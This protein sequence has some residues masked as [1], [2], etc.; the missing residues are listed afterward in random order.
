MANRFDNIPGL[1][2][3]YQQ[4]SMVVDKPFIGTDVPDTPLKAPLDFYQKKLEER[5]KKVEKLDEQVA[6]IAPLFNV[7]GQDKVTGYNGITYDINEDKEAN[8]ALAPYLKDISEI[9]D[10]AMK[11]PSS[12]FAKLNEIQQKFQTDP[13][14]RLYA[15]N[16]KTY[17]EKFEPILA[18][19]GNEEEKALVLQELTN[20]G[21]AKKQGQDYSLQAKSTVDLLDYK[22]NW[23]DLKGSLDK[24]SSK[25]EW[26]NTDPKFATSA[27]YGHLTSQVGDK[28]ILNSFWSNW[29]SDEVQRSLDHKN[30]YQTNLLSANINNAN[31]TFKRK[32]ESELQGKTSAEQQA[33]LDAKLKSDP[34]LMKQYKGMIMSGNVQFGTDK[35]TY[36]DPKA[37]VFKN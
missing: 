18:G 11:N 36:Y 35:Y 29:K 16:Q 1:P 15:E 23:N 2:Q 13:K 34:N 37:A 27:V 7:K 21:Q 28:R 33:F 26:I 17:K 19:K 22:K 31:E 9:R 30:E 5:D 20:W 10:E 8:E 14:L 32:F 24:D 3:L 4:Q 12:G 25:N 6:K